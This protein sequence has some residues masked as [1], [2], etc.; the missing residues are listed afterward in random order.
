MRA[1]ISEIEEYLIRAT[2]PLNIELVEELCPGSSQKRIGEPW[3]TGWKGMYGG[4]HTYALLGEDVVELPID[5]KP[6]YCGQWIVFTEKG[7]WY[8]NIPGGPKGHVQNGSILDIG[9]ERV[10]ADTPKERLDE[11]IREGYQRLMELIREEA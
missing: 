2:P 7:A 6:E 11:L 3:F 8:V 10:C 5:T 9:K 1:T 4:V